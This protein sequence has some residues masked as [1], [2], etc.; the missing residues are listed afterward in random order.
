MPL[1]LIYMI[2]TLIKLNTKEVMVWG[3][4]CVR[5]FKYAKA[6]D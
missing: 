3:S 1:F 2:N 6:S 5:A 4:G